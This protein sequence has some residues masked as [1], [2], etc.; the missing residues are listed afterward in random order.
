VGKYIYTR[1]IKKHSRL[2]F[3]EFLVTFSRRDFH[4]QRHSKLA[5]IKRRRLS[6]SES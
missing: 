6:E 4:K 3:F 2:R 1:R 5:A